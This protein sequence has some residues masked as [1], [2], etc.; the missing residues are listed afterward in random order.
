MGFHA[1][2]SR[3]GDGREPKFVYGDYLQCGGY[4]GEVID[5][6]YGYPEGGGKASY[7]YHLKMED[8]LFSN[9]TNHWVREEEAHAVN[10]KNYQ[11]AMENDED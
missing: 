1:L 7:Y 9:S 4:R 8:A 2:K 5:V 11:K 10:L 3:P 6:E